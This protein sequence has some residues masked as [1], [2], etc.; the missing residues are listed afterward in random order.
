MVEMITSILFQIAFPIVGV[1]LIFYMLIWGKELGQ[2]PVEITIP[3]LN[4]IL[5]ADRLTFIVLLGFVM[6]GGGGFFWYV[7]LKD[8]IN[9]MGSELTTKESLLNEFLTHNP[10]LLLFFSPEN[11]LPVPGQTDVKVFV[12]GNKD[13]KPTLYNEIYVDKGTGGIIVDIFNLKGNENY[14]FEAEYG[15]KI[16]KSNSLP[17][18]R[19]Y[20]LMNQEK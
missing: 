7:D 1:C 13:R 11:D 2:R 12:R 10:R 17:A 8:K 6:L 9:E 18:P 14:H 19:A 15:G 3:R 4:L 16:W 20:V 5:K